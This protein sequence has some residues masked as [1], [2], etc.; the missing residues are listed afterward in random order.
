M[1]EH[2]QRP[3]SA[4]FPHRAQPRILE[5]VVG[6]RGEQLVAAQAQLVDG[7]LQFD[8]GAR[9]ELVVGESGELAGVARYQA[10]QQLVVASRH[11]H[12]SPEV[13]ALDLGGPA[14]GSGV[15]LFGGL[16]ARLGWHGG[17]L[18]AHAGAPVASVGSE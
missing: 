13:V 5:G 4:E 3:L 9:L 14:V 17:V 6:E 12:H 16:R 1:N 8:L 10:G 15:D 18:L 11:E 2:W 7:A